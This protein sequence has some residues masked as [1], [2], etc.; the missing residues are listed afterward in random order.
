M[1][2]ILKEFILSPCKHVCIAVCTGVSRVPP[3]RSIVKDVCVSLRPR[4][5]VQLAPKGSLN[6]FETLSST[7]S[8]VKWLINKSICFTFG[9][10]Q[11][12]VYSSSD[13]RFV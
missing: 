4:C 7:F 11:S 1:V 10:N 3:D 9:I 2:K 13:V 5:L 6:T 12:L 8:P